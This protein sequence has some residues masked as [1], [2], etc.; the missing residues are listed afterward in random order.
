MELTNFKIDNIYIL[1]SDLE[2]DMHN[3]Y[4]CTDFHYD[5][6]EKEIVFSWIKNKYGHNKGH[7][8]WP[9]SVKLIINGVSSL[10]IEERYS[11]SPAEDALCISDFGFS[12]HDLSDNTMHGEN[13]TLS[14]D[15][16]EEYPFFC[17]VFVDHSNI[18]V[19]AKQAH[20]EFIEV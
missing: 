12:F 10:K 16:S 6:A 2:L 20:V 17:V 15:Y 8:K 3:C 13:L 4:D 7:E 1:C 18:H 19:L 9:R 5:I 14:E 11:R